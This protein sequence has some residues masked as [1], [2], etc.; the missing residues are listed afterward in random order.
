MIAVVN[1]SSRVKAGDVA[2]MV[3][4][5]AHQ[6]R[7]DASPAWGL[8]PRPVVYYSDVS[9]VPPGAWTIVIFDNADQAGVLGWHSEGPDGLPYGR[10]FAAPVLDNGGDALTKPLSVAS[11]LSHEVLEA[12]VDPPCN[13]E[14]VDGSGNRWALE[15]GDPVESDS[16][17]V[18]VSQR[19]GSQI[20]VTVSDFALPSWF[21]PL[22]KAPFDWMHKV[23]RPFTL[24]P[25]GYAVV[26][27]K[28]KF[29]EQYP[30]WRKLLREA[31][32]IEASRA[33]KP[34]IPVGR[35]A[36]RVAAGVGGA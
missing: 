34:A 19:D 13:R 20:A 3:R 26:N 24:A 32:L 5:V 33:F 6:L 4:A 35:S 2:T 21:D 10:V 31:E 16:Y 22:G 17:K 12:F 14:A 23:S 29:G 11:V 18:A 8:D 15:V 27:D 7:Y 1:K 28:E 30:S 25:G 36:R 9:H